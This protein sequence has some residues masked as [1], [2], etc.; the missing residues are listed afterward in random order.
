MRRAFSYIRFS[1]LEQS[2]GDSLRRQRKLR[3]DYVKRKKL[4][5]DESLDL[6][7]L[8]VSAY[9]GKNLREGKLADFLTAIEVGKV[10]PGDVLIVE[11]LDRFS[12]AKPTESLRVFLGIIGAGVSIVTLDPEMEFNES[13]CNEFALIEAIVKLKSANDFSARKS[14][15]GK[16]SWDSKRANIPNEKIT[17]R[18]PAW[19]QLSEDR[20]TFIEKPKAVAV[21][22]RIFKDT[23]DGIGLSKLERMLNA[24]GVPTFGNTKR[25]KVWHKSYI[26]KILHNRAVIGEFQPHTRDEDG[27]RV[28]TGKPI[29]GYFP[30]IVS[31]DDFYKAQQAMS[32]RYLARGPI[33]KDVA[34]LFKGILIDLRT[35]S[36]V[37][38]MNKNGRRLVA[39][40]AQRGEKGAE[41]ISFP[42]D[43]FE[44]A[45][46]RWAKELNPA[47]LLNKVDERTVAKSLSE[48][49]GK[50]AKV[51]INIG[52][53]RADMME[54]DYDEYRAILKDLLAQKA[55]LQARIEQLRQEAFQHKDT[56]LLEARNIISL[57]ESADGEEK[58]RLRSKLKA[59]I[60]SLVNKI[61]VLFEHTPHRVNGSRE[62]AR[63][64]AFIEVGFKSG[65]Y[66]RIFIITYRNKPF[67]VCESSKEGFEGIRIKVG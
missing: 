61:H 28:P 6:R 22:K 4:M 2:K 65:S 51:E 1:T 42:Y 11:A 49:E 41:Y 30:A 13:N 63:R 48:A 40:A 55:S 43:V 3:D 7:D 60:K 31:E 34:N 16:E 32:G 24:E 45:F 57:L 8:G 12:R 39:S 36:S 66:R 9:R 21:V 46:L 33:G 38:L 58:F 54:G 56:A 19:L 23:I 14:T 17:A 27:N 10:K 37:V 64:K 35:G 44:G 53:I 18:C 26:T 15:W 50:L 52:K 25:S 20:S 62:L 59:R 47:D 5:L 29:G 67:E